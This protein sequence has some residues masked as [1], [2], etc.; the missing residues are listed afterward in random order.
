MSFRYQPESTRVFWSPV[1]LA[2]LLR[3]GGWSLHVMT[4][5]VLLRL[6]HALPGSSPLSRVTPEPLKYLYPSISFR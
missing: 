6:C 3:I 2:A 1:K 5:E 4:S